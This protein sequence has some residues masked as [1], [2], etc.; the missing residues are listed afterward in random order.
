MSHEI[1]TPLNGI[2]GFAE[3]LNHDSV[4]SQQRKNYA[5]IIINS[6]KRLLEIINDVLDLSKIES[7]SVSLKMERT[8]LVPFFNEIF[9]MYAEKQKPDLKLKVLHPTDDSI[10]CIIDKTKL[11]QIIGNLLSNA[12]KF[13]DK[14]SITINY[15]IK[16]DKLIVKIKDTGIGI[17]KHHQEAVFNRFQQIDNKITAIKGTGLGLAIVKSLCELMGGTISLI[18]DKDSG[19]EF[20]VSIPTKYELNNEKDLLIDIQ[21]DFD[22]LSKIS[23]KVIIAEDEEINRDF[24]TSVFSKSKIEFYLAKNGVE[25]VELAHKHEDAD[26]I[27]M[28]IKMPIMNGIEATKR[29]LAKFPDAKI[30]A[31]SAYVLK[32]DVDRYELAGCID[33][34]A[35]P[36]RVNVLIDILLK[37]L[38]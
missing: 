11:F 38:K 14:G 18:S 4:D 32:E 12:F 29:I 5:G 19:A 23:G 9:L 1:R 7:G 31:H 8:D 2:L 22:S 28:D 24:F 25:A 17:E 13:T 15:I 36:F 33:F 20:T 3:L 30:V 6:G 34:M 35:K 26:L 16:S 37:Y 21:P 10:Y 27:L